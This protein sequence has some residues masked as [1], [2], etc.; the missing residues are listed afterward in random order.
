MLTVLGTAHE[1]DAGVN[2]PDDWDSLLGKTHAGMTRARMLLDAEESYK[3]ALEADP[4]YPLALIRLG[5]VQ[6]LQ[7]NPKAARC[8]LAWARSS[9]ATRTPV[10]SAPNSASI[11]PRSSQMKL[12]P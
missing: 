6:F 11:S 2:N 7:K 10:S 1:I 8:L 12:C 9:V 5:R 4:R 3:V